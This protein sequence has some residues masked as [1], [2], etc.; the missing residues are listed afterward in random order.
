MNKDEIKTHIPTYFGL[1]WY[2]SEV[3]TRKQKG[4]N[5]LSKYK[6][7]RK[8]KWKY[9]EVYQCN[10]WNNELTLQIGNNDIWFN[11]LSE[12]GEKA[13]YYLLF[14]FGTHFTKEEIKWFVDT[15][16]IIHNAN[17]E[18]EIR[19]IGYDLKKQYPNAIEFVKEYEYCDMQRLKKV[20][21]W[22]DEDGGHIQLLNGYKEEFDKLPTIESN[23]YF[24]IIEHPLSIPIGLMETILKVMDNIGE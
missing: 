1:I 12:D 16:K 8:H 23:Y 17:S 18:V 21:F 4:K 3:E 9:M 24:P 15:M 10:F 6:F 22:D 11:C 14:D 2:P 20:A 5:L 19:K 7:K 13:N